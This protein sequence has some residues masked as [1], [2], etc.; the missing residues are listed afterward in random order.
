MHSFPVIL[1]DMNTN[2]HSPI[3][4]LEDRFLEPKGWRWHDFVREGRKLRFGTLPVKEGVTPR[5]T[6]VCLP[7][8]SEFGE[9]YFE[10]AR[11]A[12]DHDL[13]FWVLDWM[14]QGRSGRYLPNPEK[15]H[16]TGFQDD[17]DDLHYFLMEYVK[18]ASVSTDVGRIPLAMLAHSMG[19]NIGLQYLAQHPDIFECATFSAP[20]FGIKDFAS[21]PKLASLAFS[22]AFKLLAGKHYVFDGSDWGGESDLLSSDPVR[23]LI[24]DQW[25]SSDPELRTG[26]VTFGWVYAALRSCFQLQN[27]EF[28]RSIQTHCTIAKAGK[29]ELV[30]NKAIDRVLHALSNASLLDLPD[31]EHEILMERD[32]IRDKFLEAFYCS[33]KENIIDRPESLKPF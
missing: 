18:H 4:D 9:K 2:T 14:G 28:L 33:I 17:I 25:L 26:N 19:G 15:R 22:G 30:D 1:V 3:P 32:P 6:V 23:N 31:S 12:R 29:E 21:S 24:F 16:S 8:L 20:M 5:A 7:G 10:T 27:P 11:W 13:S